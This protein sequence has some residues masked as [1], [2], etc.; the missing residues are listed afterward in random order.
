M[1]GARSIVKARLPVCCTNDAAGVSP[2]PQTN[3]FAFGNLVAI[4]MLNLNHVSASSGQSSSAKR[5]YVLREGSYADNA[6][7]LLQSGHAFMPD[8]AQHDPSSFW[9]SADKHERKNARLCSEIRVALPIEFTQSEQVDLIK[10]FIE[11]RLIDQPCQWAL[12]YGKGRNPHAHIIFSERKNN[13]EQQ[14]SEEV[15][16]K[17]NGAKKN[18]DLKAKEWLEETRS[19]WAD[20]SNDHLLQHGH[21]EQID[22]RRLSVQCA[23]QIEKIKV[24]LEKPEPDKILIDTCFKKAESLD[25]DPQEKKRWIRTGGQE[26]L[27]SYASRQYKPERPQTRMLEELRGSIL[28]WMVSTGEL[29]LKAAKSIEESLME[30][31]FLTAKAVVQERKEREAKQEIEPPKNDYDRGFEL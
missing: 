18:R 16:F 31:L 14:F 27:L 8:F 26:E 2:A 13:P 30:G 28:D 17:R 25:R 9:T 22:H 24:E 21:S 29:V 1:S 11:E 23:E 19:Y 7:E 5:D 6:S 10:S 4:Y 15:F 3:P 12:H 20:L